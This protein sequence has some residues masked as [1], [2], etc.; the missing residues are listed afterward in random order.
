MLCVFFAL[1]F[2]CIDWS[3][4]HG[5]NVLLVLM[6]APADAVDDCRVQLHV[7]QA[8]HVLPPQAALTAAAAA[9]QQ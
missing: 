9:S 6:E 8:G 7:A 5:G 4:C 3:V 1:C 2:L